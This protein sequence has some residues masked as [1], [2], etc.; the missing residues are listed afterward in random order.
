MKKKGRIYLLPSPLGEEGL[1]ALPEYGRAIMRDLTFFVAERAKTTRALLKAIDYPRPIQEAHIEELNKRTRLEGVAPLLAPVRKGHDLG[2][3]SEAGCPGIA[4]PGARLVEAAHREGIQVVPVVGPS[5][6]LLALMGSG[7]SGQQFCF[8]GYLSPKRPQLGKDLKRLE[9]QASRFKQTQIFMETPYRNMA[10]LEEAVKNLSPSTRF[11][12][13]A[14]LTLP[15][16]YIFTQT[17]AE[18]KKKP[19]PDLHKRPAIFLIG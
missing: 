1:Q 2:M 17:I 11:A 10:V 5:S 16:E 19:L 9:Q 8:H 18:W 15:T 4:D 14:D 12:V 3:I 6:I 13:A 7:L